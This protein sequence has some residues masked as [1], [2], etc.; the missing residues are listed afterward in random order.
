[1]QSYLLAYFVALE[2]FERII[3][4]VPLGPFRPWRTDPLT[5]PEEISS[6]RGR[7]RPFLRLP[8]PVIRARFWDDV[9]DCF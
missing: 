3:F 9:T 8:R 7:N 4:F 1:M 2:D 5:V 6:Y